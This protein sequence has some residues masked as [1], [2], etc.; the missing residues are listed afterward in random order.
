[1]L[2]RTPT[3]ASTAGSQ[4]P[5]ATTSEAS[6]LAREGPLS[7]HLRSMSAV[8]VA[9]LAGVRVPAAATS[10]QRVADA[11]R[12]RPAASKPRASRRGAVVMASG[13]IEKLQFLTPAEAVAVREE[14]GTPAYVYDMAR[15]KEQAAKALDFPNA[16]GL[17][18]A[19]FL[20][21]SCSSKAAE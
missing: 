20:P 13:D 3:R 9:S 5:P 14:F 17:T 2:A 15:L 18:K 12:V 6:S 10:R 11:R 4:V 16:F 1:M 8:A 7:F 21:V 19:Y